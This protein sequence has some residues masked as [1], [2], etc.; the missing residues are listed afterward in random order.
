MEAAH[1]WAPLPSNRHHRSNGDCLEGKRENY[2]CNLVCNNCAQC[3]TH[4]W[5]DPTV[6]WIR[7]CLTGPI[8]LCLDSFLRMYV[9]SV[10]QYIACMS[11]IVTLSVIGVVSP[12]RSSS[13]SVPGISSW[14]FLGYTKASGDSTPMMLSLPST[15]RQPI[16]ASTD[17]LHVEPTALCC[18]FWRIA[19]TT[20]RRIRSRRMASLSTPRQ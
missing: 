13:G 6:L 11:S 4:I 14:F 20:S 9:F 19:S 3:N 16:F 15:S 18:W 8:S 10:W 17:R 1:W 5:T 2:L 7:F 12:G